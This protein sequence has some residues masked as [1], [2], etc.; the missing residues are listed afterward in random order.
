MN[1]ST[2]TSNT[3]RTPEQRGTTC[4]SG[5]VGIRGFSGG[6][7]PSKDNDVTPLT[8]E[9]LDLKALETVKPPLLVRQSN[10]PRHLTYENGIL[11]DQD[12]KPTTPEQHNTTHLEILENIRKQ[13]HLCF[14]DDDDEFLDIIAKYIPSSFDGNPPPDNACFD[15]NNNLR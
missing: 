13:R 5:S 11:V 12:G 4:A 8:E 9:E 10:K 7:L 6:G 1:S 14:I 15:N 3:V 2:N